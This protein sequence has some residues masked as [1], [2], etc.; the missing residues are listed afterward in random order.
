MDGNRV[1]GFYYLESEIVLG[2]F[3]AP[4]RVRQTSL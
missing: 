3:T 1:I 4:G 2:T